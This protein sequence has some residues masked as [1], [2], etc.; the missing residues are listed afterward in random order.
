MR[1]D[2]ESRLPR[3]GD[4]GAG[5]SG[6]AIAPGTPVTGALLRHGA[7]PSLATDV[8]SVVPGQVLTAT[9][10]ALAHQ[11]GLHHARHRH[12]TGTH[13]TTPTV[14]AKQALAWASVE[15]AKAL[16]LGDQV[17]RIEPGMRADLVAM[18][19]RALKLWPAHNPVAAVLHAAIAN[20]EAVM[21]GGRWR[22]RDHALLHPGLDEIKDRL[23]ES[24]GR[25]LDT[26]DTA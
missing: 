5:G 16:G 2:R 3:G 4:A 11:R 1:R 18:D 26:M 6:C 15:G 14:T 9:R 21:G 20:I 17:G 8:D 10:I 23:P 12:D 25:L 24:G 22:K 13:A 19:T 7:A